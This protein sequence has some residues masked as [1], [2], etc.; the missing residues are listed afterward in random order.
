MHPLLQSLSYVNT[1]VAFLDKR[2]RHQF[3]STTCPIMRRSIARAGLANLKAWFAWLRGTELF[4]I[5]WRDVELTPPG[6]GSRH[7]VPD[8]VGV[9]ELRL[10]EATKTSRTQTA[11]MALA[12]EASSGLS[13]GF[14]S[15]TL[16]TELHLDPNDWP[17]T[18][19]FLFVHESGLARSS[20]F[21]PRNVPHPEPPRAARGRRSLPLG[22]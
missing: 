12:Y 15:T 14:W 2:L 20:R 17:A 8:P 3:S 16:A 9:I 4:S 19:S 6:S 1:D 13:M 11:D 10:L 21:F 5:R 18:V 7:D 22:I